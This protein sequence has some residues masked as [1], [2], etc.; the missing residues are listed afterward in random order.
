M[1]SVAPEQLLVGAHGVAEE[2]GASI[3]SPPQAGF[4]SSSPC[5]GNR[6]SRRCRRPR[7]RCSFRRPA[8]VSRKQRSRLRPSRIT[9]DA[10][11]PA[12]PCIPP[13]HPR[14]AVPAV[15]AVARGAAVPRCLPWRRRRPSRRCRRSPHGFEW[16]TDNRRTKCKAAADHQVRAAIFMR[17]PFYS[18]HGR[19]KARG[20]A[21][22]ARD[23]KARRANR[24]NAG[25]RF[26]LGWTLGWRGLLG[27]GLL[28]VRSGRPSCASRP[29]LHRGSAGGGGGGRRRGSG[30]SGRF[31][32]RLRRGRRRWF[33]LGR[34]GARR[35]CCSNARFIVRTP[36]PATRSRR[37][38]LRSQHGRVPSNSQSA[39]VDVET[40]HW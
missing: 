16:G 39:C 13:A 29:R 7:R 27:S 37:S 11:V 25:P 10:R 9:G 6:S 14:I 12:S 32:N 18:S 22:E 1:R 17:R 33:A 30:G 23:S 28:D 34:F 2:L 15:P 38:R 19:S 3:H 31:W 35:R 20:L 24:R 8:G 5:R 40:G 36:R 26:G 4:R 21:S